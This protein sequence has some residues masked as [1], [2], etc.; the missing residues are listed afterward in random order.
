LAYTRT[1]SVNSSTYTAVTMQTVCGKLEVG[2][3]AQTGTSDWY[4]SNTGSDS[5]KV[6]RPAGQRMVLEN[7]MSFRPSQVVG[8]IKTASGSQTFSQVESEG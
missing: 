8:Y 2:E 1:F 5:D 4:F 6:T 7:P 3:D